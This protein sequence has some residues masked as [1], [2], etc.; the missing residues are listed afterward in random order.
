MR[1]LIVILLLTLTG[2]LG[3]GE[4][5]VGDLLRAIELT[6]C[7]EGRVKLT[8]TISVGGIPGFSNELHIDLEENHT[9]ESIRQNPVCGR[10]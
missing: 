10:I 1:F 7:E 2:C 8:G 9:P 3:K 5:A 6:E 4:S